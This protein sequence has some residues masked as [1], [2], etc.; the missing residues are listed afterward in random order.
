MTDPTTLLCVP[1][2]TTALDGIPGVEIPARSFA[3]GDTQ[4]HC[5]GCRRLVWLGAMQ[6]A[7]HQLHPDALIACYFCLAAVM[8]VERRCTGY[9]PELNVRTL[10]PRR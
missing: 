5:Q 8:E 2:D 9:V 4:T 3:Q 1:V 6:R 7:H 10:D